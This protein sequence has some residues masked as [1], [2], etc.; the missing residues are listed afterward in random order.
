MPVAERRRC[1]VSDAASTQK[2]VNTGEALRQPAAPKVSY[3]VT[4]VEVTSGER[5][6]Q[7]Y[8]ELV[9]AVVGRGSSRAGETTTEAVPSV[10]AKVGY[11]TECKPFEEKRTLF[12]AVFSTR[13]LISE[14]AKL[15]EGGQP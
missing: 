9:S 1:S 8:R 11:L 3:V 6:E 12:N 2:I 10:P 13:P 5:H 14:L 4:V 15:M 7:N